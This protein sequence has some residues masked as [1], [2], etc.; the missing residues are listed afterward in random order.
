VKNESPRGRSDPISA[1]HAAGPGT[2]GA[3]SASPHPGNLPPRFSSAQ[4]GRI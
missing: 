1:P 3:S 2:S 4:P